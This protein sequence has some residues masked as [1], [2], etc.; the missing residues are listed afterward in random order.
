MALQQV[1]IDPKL[2]A[3]D[4]IRQSVILAA[5]ARA[6]T[7]E[8]L[9]KQIWRKDRER[10]WTYDN[11]AY[12]F[13]NGRLVTFIRGWNIKSE[14]V[15]PYK[16]AKTDSWHQDFGLNQLFV[17]QNP[18][19]PYEGD[20]GGNDGIYH[21]DCYIQPKPYK[22]A[23]GL[24]EQYVFVKNELFGDSYVGFDEYRFDKQDAKG[25]VL[26]NNVT[27][28]LFTKTI[29]DKPVEWVRL[30]VDHAT[31]GTLYY[32]LGAS[33]GMVL[34]FFTGMLS[35]RET[36]K[37]WVIDKAV[38]EAELVAEHGTF[39]RINLGN[40]T[41]PVFLISNESVALQGA[42]GEMLIFRNGVTIEFV[43]YT[44]DDLG[45]GGYMHY[46]AHYK[47]LPMV[48]ADT[49]YLVMP[50]K[51]YLDNWDDMFELVVHEN[52]ELWEKFLKPVLAI[53]TIVI[54]SFFPPAA[55]LLGIIQGLG[56]ALTVVGILS[57]DRK[58]GL[59]GGILT[60]GASLATNIAK[61]GISQSVMQSGLSE[62]TAAQAAN[63]ATITLEHVFAGFSQVGI[64][65]IFEVGSKVLSI[66]SDVY[67]LTLDAP[68]MDEAEEAV[69]DVGRVIFV[70]NK[71][72]EE[73]DILN[74]I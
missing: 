36:E 26:I 48:Y 43:P 4:N 24:I 51:F 21:D 56:V 7:Y 69:D 58:I 61:E 44:V 10:V 3:Y 52:K 57:G 53:V 40:K 46:Q 11:P 49:G 38:F 6:K 72:D 8:L 20:V 30:V 74:V 5:F 2:S 50:I 42:D 59:I 63:E 45:D 41:N 1:Y 54:S 28:E 65:N 16:Y 9:H 37:Q 29:K 66:G 67:G 17:G 15:N 27:V 62:R 68:V 23:S 64:G 71:E 55:G 18:K 35:L 34:I 19:K 73:E 14:S 39:T 22:L 32:E 33:N 47:V 70:D 25:V 31:K 13:H 12:R 60:A